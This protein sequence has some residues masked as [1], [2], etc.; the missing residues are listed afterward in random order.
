MKTR[1]AII[2][3]PNARS[4]GVPHLLREFNS[5]FYNSEYYTSHRRSAFRL[6]LEE[7]HK[8]G[9][10]PYVSDVVDFLIRT[11][12]AK[13]LGMSYFD[14]LKLDPATYRFIRDKVIKSNE[15]KA[16]DLTEVD[17]KLK[18]ETQKTQQQQNGGNR[19]ERTKRR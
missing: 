19:R 11:D 5:R 9:P 2:K 14:F 8:V 16:K 10:G 4:I 1:A 17:Q 13:T 15:Q 18:Q 12:A 6:D 3:S 7:N